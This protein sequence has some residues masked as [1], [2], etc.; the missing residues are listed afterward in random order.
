MGNCGQV[1]TGL[2]QLFF[3]SCIN[4][5][6]ST[7]SNIGVVEACKM[8]LHAKSCKDVAEIYFLK[9][10]QLCSHHSH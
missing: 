4:K 5:I 1:C 3:I 2:G 9:P 6:Q 8:S 7:S 10:E